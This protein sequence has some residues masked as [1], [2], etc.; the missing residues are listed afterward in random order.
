MLQMKKVALHSVIRDAKIF[1]LEGQNLEKDTF[2]VERRFQ[3][4]L[5]LL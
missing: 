1:C 3:Q 2:Y 5:I 4:M